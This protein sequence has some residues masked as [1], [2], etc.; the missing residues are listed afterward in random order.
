MIPVFFWTLVFSV[1]TAI[2]IVLL[3]QRDLISGNLF[4][5]KKLFFLMTNWKFIIS[6]IAA[7]LARVAFMMTN[8]SLLKIPRLAEASTTITTFITLFCLV[9]VVIVNA[10]F[11]QERISIF[12]GAGAF[13]I[14]VGILIM[15]K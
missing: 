12:Q 11:L 4:E 6:M 15:L 14:M 1:A 10:V 9:F 8:N 13:L 7:V 3:G 2:S 5:I